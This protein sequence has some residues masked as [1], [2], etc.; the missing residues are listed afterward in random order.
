M[1]LKK[2]LILAFLFFLPFITVAASEYKAYTIPHTQVIPIKNTK[3]GEQYELYIQLPT[4]Y[5]KRSATKYPVFY[6]TDAH[7]NLKLLSGAS[8]FLMEDVILVGISYQK[9][10]DRLASRFRDYTPAYY[11]INGYKTG[12][13]DN[14]FNFI[15]NDVIKYV[16][17]NY[18]TIPEQRTYFGFSIGGLFG[19][20]ILLT[21]PD[22]FQNYILGSPAIY[23]KKHSTYYQTAYNSA[24]KRN[25]SNINVFVSYGE[26]ETNLGKYNDDFV[27]QLKSGNY[28]GLSIEKKIIKSAD[29]IKSFP[30]TVIR[31]LYWLSEL[32]NE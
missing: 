29:H 32:T 24:L 19:T 9:N 1:N 2:T 27:A 21:Q 25:K 15:R 23:N 12:N 16:E 22:T 11:T 8:G 31:S 10:V 18:R 13:A 14:F 3:S 30:E 4:E 26:L 17:D 7:E 5:S 6:I 28:A 20:H